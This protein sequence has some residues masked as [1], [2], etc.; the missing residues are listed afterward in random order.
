MSS[1]D[2]ERRWRADGLRANLPLVLQI[3]GV[4]LHSWVTLSIFLSH[5]CA[6]AS[7]APRCNLQPSLVLVEP[8]GDGSI[9]LPPLCA[10]TFSAVGFVVAS[11]S[12]VSAFKN[13]SVFSGE[14]SR[15]I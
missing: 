12:K 9:G 7:R 15:S 13:F 1:D 10:V 3:D 11:E 2:R 5:A 4:S 6:L 14:V 8:W